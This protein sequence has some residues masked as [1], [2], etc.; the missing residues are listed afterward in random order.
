MTEPFRH[1]DGPPA[2][3]FC[4][5]AAGNERLAGSP[6]FLAVLDG[7][8]LTPGHT[9]VIPRAHV[10]SLFELTPAEVGEAY[11]LLS[12]ARTLIQAR[13]APDGFN[14]GVNDG[15]AAGRTVHHLHIH[16]I[17]RYAGDVP[18]P[19]GGIRLM[20]PGPSPDLWA[21]AYKPEKITE[22]EHRG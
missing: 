15:A 18:D 14:V 16:L 12:E 7:Y 4:D 6:R 8:P 22:E 21:S 9:L 17:P 20:M 5:G 2:C 1:T 19:R 11:N 13:H 3:I 10:V